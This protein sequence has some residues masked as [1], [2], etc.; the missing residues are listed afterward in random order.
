MTET[1]HT[2]S[3]RASLYGLLLQVLV[4]GGVLGLSEATHSFALF[5]LAWYTAG[6]ITLWFIC[7]LLFR[8]REL[9]AL[10]ALDVEE[11]RREKQATGAGETIFGEEGGG[12]LGFRVAESRLQWMQRWLVPVFGLLN[13]A[14]LT[15]MGL[16][17]WYRFKSLPLMG[18]EPLLNLPIA[19]IVLAVAM[20][21]L[22][23]FS[24]YASGM[25]RVAEWQPLR[26]CG[27]YML[28]NALGAMALI[29]CFGVYLYADVAAAEHV[30]AYVILVV[31]LLLAA[32][33]V[34]NFILDVY[35]P[36]V[37]GVEPRACFDSRLLALIAEPGGIASTIAEAMN[38]QFGFEVSQT[39]FYQLLQRTFVPLIGAG[40]VMLWLLT[41]V[42]VVQPGENAIIERYG[43]Q[44][45]AAQPYGPG[46][47]W[48]APWP[49]DVAYKYNTG[50]LHQ[51]I[52][53]F[54]QF[55]ALPKEPK[56]K[57]VV[58]LWTDTEHM[59]QPHFEFLVPVPAGRLEGPAPVATAP[60]GFEPDA[61]RI[62]QAWPVN[63]VRMDVAIQY[64]IV[65]ARLAAYTQHLFNPEDTLRDIAWEEVV[66][67]TA[68]A[69]IFTLLG[70]KYGTA[71]AE[72]QERIRRRLEQL[73]LGLEV[74]Y[75]GVQ[76]IHPEPGVAKQFREVVKAE[77]DKIASIREALVK[78]NQVLSAVAGD[79][80]TA[81]A[82]AYAI[83]N[84]NPNTSLL[85]RSDQVLEADD[86][87]VVRAAQ[88]R[89][90]AL[91]PDFTRV[92]EAQWKLTLAQQ[93]HRQ[94]E[95]DFELGLGLNMNDKAEAARRVGD[96]QNALAAAQATLDDRL[97]PILAEAGQKLKA[98]SVA[99]LR[100]H[101]QARFALE[102][103]NAR[104][105][106]LLPDLQGEAAG[107]L[108]TAQAER[109]SYEMS[110]AG[111]VARSQGEGEAFRAAPRIYK[112]R[113]YLA[114]LVDGLRDSRK[115]FLA[116][117]PHGRTVRVRFEAQEQARTDIPSI[118]T[119][120]PR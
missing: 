59:G 2:R 16:Y 93:Q 90:A 91:A 7:L 100:D 21:L 106:R 46:F 98:T 41:C 14:Y 111:E 75:V 96:A 47:Y 56:E 95:G 92:V 3:R 64:K 53:G 112:V 110:A 73:D 10:E 72:L 42:L 69:D 48:K 13:A 86:P 71:G 54:K 68:V 108:A 67:Y 65:E 62:E 35:R 34:V 12:A 97:A 76:N 119:R 81:R 77:Q 24:R 20:L 78:E 107:I 79:R 26:A 99:A 8:Q 30:L 63:M 88:E 89:M 52:V 102:F 60:T 31:M 87:A 82:L 84:L 104:L 11:L 44:L 55:D 51:I 120:A 116:F 23:L 66:R 27:S 32:E 85:D 105:T 83:G 70:P 109:W 6:G 15:G 57:N 36:R 40:A 43:R 1:P 103:W 5:S 113:E 19:M 39:W 118:E 115:Y 25:G 61:K 17:L 117:D 4:F 33:T 101:I 49:I 80:D 29:V 18:A 94:I 114:A 28:G 37:R 38:Y 50:Q 9:V 74:V 45:N 22:F 58:A